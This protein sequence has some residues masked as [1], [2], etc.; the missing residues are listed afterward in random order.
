MRRRWL[1][2]AVVAVCV[3]TVGAL[4]ALR[5]L[6]LAGTGEP[7]AALPESKR[8]DG[9]AGP[10]VPGDASAFVRDVTIPDGTEVPT[11]AHFV[12]TWELRNAGTVP[13]VDRYLRSYGG[14][15][16]CVSA[17]RVPIPPTR[18]GETVAISVEVRAPD[19]PGYCQVYWKMVDAKDRLLLPG[20]RGV[21]YLVEVVD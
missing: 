15:G 1:A 9:P 19:E 6:D 13:W 4:V 16:G 7:A 14:P 3:L 8:P 18:P 17:E 11:G 10:A 12:K 20:N 21:Y 2:A 5:Y